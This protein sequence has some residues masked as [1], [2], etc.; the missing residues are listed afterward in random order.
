VALRFVDPKVHPQRPSPV[1][2]DPI[3]AENALA[4]VKAINF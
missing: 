3:V 4:L 1:E 2:L